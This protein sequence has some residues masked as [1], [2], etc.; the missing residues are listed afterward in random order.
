MFNQLLIAAA[1]KSPRPEHRKLV[2][3]LIIERQALKDVSPLTNRLTLKL[4]HAK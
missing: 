4:S 1:I 3:H 2:E